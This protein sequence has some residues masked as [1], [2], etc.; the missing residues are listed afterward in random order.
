MHVTSR[1]R[2]KNISYDGDTTSAPVSSYSVCIIKLTK[3]QQRSN[4]VRVLRSLQ[5][6]VWRPEP[7]GAKAP[8]SPTPKLPSAAV[9]QPL[10]WRFSHRYTQ[11][12]KTFSPS[13]SASLTHRQPHSRQPIPPSLHRDQSP[14]P[15]RPPPRAPPWR[16]RCATVPTRCRPSKSS[17]ATSGNCVFTQSIRCRRHALRTC[18]HL[19][20][21]TSHFTH[22]TFACRLEPCLFTLGH[23]ATH[24]RSRGGCSG[25]AR[26]RPQMVHKHG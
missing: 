24:T 19:P 25:L 23:G 21:Q 9:A 1:T 11:N 3:S 5:A 15:S 20:A 18:G 7:T 10:R 22:D 26:L 14:L 12:P 4:A 8:H 2:C 6:C 16:H 13:I 17:P